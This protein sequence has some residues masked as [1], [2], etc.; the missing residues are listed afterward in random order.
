MCMESRETGRRI[1]FIMRVRSEE[2]TLQ[3]I[4]QWV[5]LCYLGQPQH[6]FRPAQACYPMLL[7]QPAP[8]Q[9]ITLAF[10]RS[11]LPLPQQ[12]NSSYS[13]TTPSSSRRAAHPVQI[14]L[15]QYPQISPR[16]PHLLQVKAVMRMVV[17]SF[18][19]DRGRRKCILTNEVLLAD[20][21]SSSS[22]LIPLNG[23]TGQLRVHVL[24]RIAG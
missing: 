15:L 24:T 14:F 10:R 4:S 8:P 13:V 23:T 16:L 1:K 3:K 11:F 9:S 12:A 5:K 17:L 19:S 6:C 7:M 2:G 18:S 22:G 20:S 21:S